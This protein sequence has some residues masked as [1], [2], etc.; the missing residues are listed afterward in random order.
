MFK[1]GSLSVAIKG[2]S[3]VENSAEFATKEFKDLLTLIKYIGPNYYY[4]NSLLA[5]FTFYRSIVVVLSLVTYYLINYNK[6][7]VSLFDGFVI[8]AFH[9]L[10]CVVPI[11]LYC[12][13]IDYDKY[14]RKIKYVD[15]HNGVF[16]QTWF[17]TKWNM[18]GFIT[19]VVNTYL[20]YQYFGS[21]KEFNDIL[22]LFLI[23]I[24]NFKLLPYIKDVRF[25]NYLVGPGLFLLYSL[26]KGSF[27]GVISSLF[28]NFEG[29]K[30]L[31][32]MIIVNFIIN[33]F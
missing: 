12:V 24:L 6:P 22:T 3:Y 5:N 15:S 1:S 18:I 26:I 9:I 21:Y 4:K 33:L 31:L 7:T 19:S 14:N 17:T 2:H 28:L 25:V 29:I 30:F 20:T 27:F 10:W 13:K 32:M 23:I 16:S 8:Q 11:I